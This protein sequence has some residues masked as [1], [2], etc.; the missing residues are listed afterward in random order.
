[1]AASALA[2]CG[3]PGVVDDGRPAPTT[4]PA[5]RL[6]A[7]MPVGGGDS[8]SAPT[9]APSISVPT[10]LLP[11]GIRLPEGV[12]VARAGVDELL[13]TIPEQVLAFGLD[14][15]HPVDQ[16]AAQRVLR[17][18]AAAVGDLRPGTKIEVSG[19]ASADG[20]T[21]DYDLTLSAAR[22]AWVCARLGELGLEPS[23]LECRGAGREQDLAPAGPGPEDRRVEI[24][25]H[26]REQP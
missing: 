8:S 23:R 1:M 19:H 24:R 5:P 10:T 16:P 26:T 11:P 3:G 20:P 2:A 9:S 22:A 12:A 4:V 14:S 7:A 13:I 6:V 17:A 25:V 18:I 21:A 15:D